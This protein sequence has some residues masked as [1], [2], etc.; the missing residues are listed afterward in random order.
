MAYGARSLSL[1]NAI[2]A[3]AASV[4]VPSDHR[5]IQIKNGTGPPVKIDLEDMTFLLVKLLL[6]Q[7]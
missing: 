3:Q 6:T 2:A 1:A 4:R 5:P 7:P